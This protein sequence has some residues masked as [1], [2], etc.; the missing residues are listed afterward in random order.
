MLDEAAVQVSQFLSTDVSGRV[1]RG[2]EVQI[3]LPTAVEL[4]GRHVHP[5]D[6]LV[7]VAG[8]VDGCFQQLQS[9]TKG[10]R[11]SWS[12]FKIKGVICKNA[13]M[14]VDEHRGQHITAAN[15]TAITVTYAVVRKR[16]K[17]LFAQLACGFGESGEFLVWPVSPLLT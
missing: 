9:C 6:D 8:L 11:R 14:N 15:E 5:D 16:L 12:C 1:I 7:G 2:L 4:G 10:C 13:K 17:L 3:V